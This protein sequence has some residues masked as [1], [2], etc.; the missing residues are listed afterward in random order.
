MVTPAAAPAA[1]APAPRRVYDYRKIIIRADSHRRPSRD[2]GQIW[3]LDRNQ[4]WKSS[5]RGGYLAQMFGK[6]ALRAAADER[7]RR[8][9][10]DPHR[11]GLFGVLSQ[12]VAQRTRE[13]G[14]QG[15]PRSA[16]PRV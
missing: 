2:Q 8:R 13:I 1:T 7:I 4:P 16:P 3:Q 9:R 6:Q 12:A 15:R 10:A 11:G 14:H 5:A